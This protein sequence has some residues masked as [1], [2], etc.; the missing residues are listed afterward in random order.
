MV[1][2]LKS[3]IQRVTF[4]TFA[5]WIIL[6]ASVLLFTITAGRVQ[7]ETYELTEFQIAPKTIR[8]TKTVEDTIKTERERE[9]VAQEVAPSY[10]YSEDASS[11]RQ[12][13]AESIFDHIRS[14]Q[15]L[16]KEQNDLTVADLTKEVRVK[17]DSL[18]ETIGPI[19]LTDHQIEQLL[20][21]EEKPLTLVS[22][23]VV[24]TLKHVLEAPIRKEQLDEAR[25]TARSLIDQNER[26]PNRLK[27]TSGDL[28]A[29]LVTETEVVNVE[30]TENRIAKEKEAVEPV[31]ILQ[32]QV[33][34]REGQV[35]D[36]ET[37]RQL[38]IA[39]LLDR[40]Q[41]VKPLLGL[42]LYLLL[43]GFIMYLHFETTKGES[44][45]KKKELAIVYTVLILLTVMMRL[46]AM[47]DAEFDVQ[48]A[49]LF[50]T[51]LAPLLVKVLTNERLAIMTTIVTAATAGLMLQ[52]GYAA[53]LQM[54]L[55]VYI[56]FGGL[57]SLYVL[58]NDGRRSNILL[59]SVGVALAN[60][61]FIC[62][63]LL[64]TQSNYSWEEIGFYVTAAV[65]SGLLSGALTIG[66][67][68]F[69]ETVFG[70][71]SDVKLIELSN[72][73]QPLLRKLLTETPGTYHHSIMVA[74]LAETACEAIGAN[75]LVARVG[76]YYHDIGKTIRPE[77]FIENQHSGTN[78][79]DALPPEKSKDI[80][81][82][83]AVDGTRMLKEH[84]LP[85]E[86]VDIAE[87]HHGTSFLQF[88]YHKAK[89]LGQDVTEDDFRYPGPKAQT[90]EAA[91]VSI[92]DSTEAAV[93]SMK[94]PTPEKIE[95]LVQS[96]IR[97]KLTDGQF[98]EC[99]LSVRELKIVERAICATLNGIFHSRIEYPDVEEE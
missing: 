16:G 30:L 58:G 78:P 42:A 91:V 57:V 97:G 49:F 44:T 72:P 39:G 45:K 54:E 98:D 35:I 66:V 96:I 29:A 32:G 88:F 61:L 31:R 48:V 79:H 7:H 8:A 94:E 26:I 90:K 24:A 22:E 69:F 17:L 60:L 3:A 20:A 40:Q 15:Q 81:I 82:A 70:I 76:S 65:V 11:N 85:K 55:G 46:L 83:H 92:A 84:G 80:I 75:G 18:A 36:S 4:R 1:Q 13:V 67:L 86:V 95:H 71:L 43:V 87:Q 38:E 10:Q 50:P 23:E 59:T 2:R 52:E 27:R 34:V 6:I 9:R 77:Y 63:Y 19:D 28:V 68:P 73:S 37:Y 47:I 64:M 56:L 93:R 99:D 21:L 51:A 62:F 89:E 53:I 74:N 12:A 33:I 25:E 14:V 41:S 5:M